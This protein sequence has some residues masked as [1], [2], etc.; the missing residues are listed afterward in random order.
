MPQETNEGYTAEERQYA[1]DFILNGI[2]AERDPA[3]ILDELSTF[4]DGDPTDLF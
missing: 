3:D 2:A 1:R 4:Y